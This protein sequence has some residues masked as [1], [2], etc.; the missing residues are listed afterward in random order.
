M[1]ESTDDTTA[2]EEKAQQRVLDAIDGR[3][4]ADFS[5]LPKA[6]RRLSAA[7]LQR[8]I[9]GSH[10]THGELSCPLRIR[11]A[12]V[13][14]PLLP[15]SATN[16]FG[17]AAVQFRECSFDSPVD[18]S[19]AQFLVLRFIDCALPAFIGASLHV[20]ADLDLSGSRISG[21]SDYESE[22]SQVGS[23]A[24]HLN[25]ARIGGNLNISSTDR[26]RFTA[27]GTIRL[28]G[29]QIDGS[30]C[31]AGALLDGRGAPAVSGRD[32]GLSQFP[33]TSV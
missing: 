22:L 19:G 8:L 9:S 24:I 18:L 30:I 33:A 16:H 15:P 27:A 31:L 21:V 6:E 13:T 10:D 7:F 14:G 29:A 28:D 2:F 23:V 11:G 25:N 32:P 20:S 17:R 3:Q 5:S 12:D 1:S 26:S 4:V